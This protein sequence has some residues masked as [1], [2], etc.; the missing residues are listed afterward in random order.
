[1]DKK[2][3]TLS[4]VIDFVIKGENSSKVDS[5]EEEDIVVLPP[6]KR[7]E[8]EADCDSDSSEDEN[9]RLAHHMPCCL[10]TPHAQQTL[11]N[12]ILMTAIKLVMMQLTS[13]QQLMIPANS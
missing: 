8:V 7:A 13:Y 1:M 4:E 11:L 3:Y 10:L 2:N 6:I 12:K 5:D 9:E